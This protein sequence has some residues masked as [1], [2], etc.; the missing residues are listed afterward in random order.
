MNSS[1]I[2][3]TK[4][5][6]KDDSIID[7]EINVRGINIDGKSYLYASARD[8]TEKKEY[9]EQRELLLSSLGDGVYG[10]DTQGICTFINKSALEMIG[11]DEGEVIGFNQHDLFHHHYKDDKFYPEE[12]CPIYKTTVDGVTRDIED[13]FIRK[14]GEHFDVHIKVAPIIKSDKI[15]GAVVVFQDI[16]QRKELEENMESINKYLHKKVKE[17]TEKR[18]EK[19]HLLIQQSKLA[20]MGE[21]ISN[22]A[23]HWRQPLNMLAIDVQDVEMAYDANELDKEYLHKFKE[24]SMAT[25]K[26]MSKTIDNFKGLYS[27]D[28]EKEN[29]YIKEAIHSAVSIV[30]ENLQS[31]NIR[32]EIIEPKDDIEFYGYK[33]ELSQVVVNILNNSKDI[34]S[35]KH[36]MG[37]AGMIKIGITKNEESLKISLTDNGG[38]IPNDI[39]ERV[40]EPY[41]TTKYKAQGVGLSLYISKL[42]IEHDMN[43][44]LSV[45][46]IADGACF[47]IDLPL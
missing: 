45:H 37:E 43:G 25:I 41:F 35:S 29:F 2:F 19:E 1:A 7:V 16:R 34:L 47:E 12:D 4:Q 22:I 46:N 32:T 18:L 14:S 20:S 31:L 9:E 44:K 30:Q 21:M 17:E 10:I 40:F 15:T 8:I 24:T 13:M 36:D 5:R 38:G 42:I 11:F 3:E 26:N 6:K 27:P 28:S 23:H 33:N 39:I